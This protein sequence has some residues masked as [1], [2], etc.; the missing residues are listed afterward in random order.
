MLVAGRGLEPHRLYLWSVSRSPRVQRRL[1]PTTEDAHL[2][3]ASLTS[4]LSIER[5]QSVA[6]RVP[7]QCL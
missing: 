4:D 6:A 3:L 1:I 5:A 2:V 7:Q